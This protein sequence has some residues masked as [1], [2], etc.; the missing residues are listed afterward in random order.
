MEKGKREEPALASKAI[1]QSDERT[2]R[3]NVAGQKQNNR[4]PPANHIKRH[5][6]D[7]AQCLAILGQSPPGMIF[8]GAP[9][10]PGKHI[11]LTA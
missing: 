2:G 7:T 6:K 4:S 3:G 5:N 11:K 1:T 9:E 10:E 8:I